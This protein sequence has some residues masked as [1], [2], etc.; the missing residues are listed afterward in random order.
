MIGM[1]TRYFAEAYSKVPLEIPILHNTQP[2][3]G[4][5]G[6]FIFLFPLRNFDVEFRVHS[7]GSFKSSGGWAVI[8]A[9]PDYKT[10]KAMN[11]E[12]LR[13]WSMNILPIP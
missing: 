13:A 8:N 6:L 11:S 5:C 12:L 2:Q 3:P 7:L 4:S 9:S 1:R 10:R